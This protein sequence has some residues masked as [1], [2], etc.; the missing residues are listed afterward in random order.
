MK[1]V[2]ITIAVVVALAL[3]GSS[4]LLAQGNT[5]VWAG[6]WKLNPAKSKFTGIPAPK[7]ETRTVEAQGRALKFTFEGIAADGSRIAYSF[8]SDLDGKPVPE[9]GS[10]TTNGSE[11][12]TIK[13]IDS[14]TTTSTATRAG[15]VVAT[16][17]TVVSK[18][19]KTTTITAKGTS[20]NGQPTSTVTV[21][22][23]Q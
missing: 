1:R 23:K 17:Q 11:M 18:D 5:E 14:N 7:S 9:S 8:T 2:F 13:L 10:G 3:A 19:G 6:T 12:I 20:V 15:K 4:L 22:D 21:W 16:N